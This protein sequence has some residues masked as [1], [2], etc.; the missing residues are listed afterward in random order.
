MA[1]SVPFIHK[2]SPET[3]IRVDHAL[4]ARFFV[5][6]ERGPTSFVIRGETG[7][8]FKV[9]IGSTHHCSCAPREVPCI[10]VVRGTHTR[11]QQRDMN[12]EADTQRTLN[13]GEKRT[14]RTRRR[15]SFP[16]VLTCTLA[17]V[18]QNLSE[19]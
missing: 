14:R 17:N 4:L 10:H 1:R 7:Q 15:R 9:L 8:K 13:R 12:F 5:V 18:C 3:Q 6:Q 19:T 16:V 11:Q 2:P